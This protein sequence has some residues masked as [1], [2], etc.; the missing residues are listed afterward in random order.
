MFEPN[1]AASGRWQNK[2]PLPVKLISG[3]C[4]LVLLVALS[5]LHCSADTIA[6]LEQSPRTLHSWSESLDFAA[7]QW[8]ENRVPQTYIRQLLKAAEKAL[9]QER[10]QIRR[11]TDASP[12]QIRRIKAEAER[13]ESKIHEQRQMLTRSGDSN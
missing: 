5:S 1:Y 9:A 8:A 6:A 4:A 2:H 10:A 3:S 7:E 13:L 11:A 12:E